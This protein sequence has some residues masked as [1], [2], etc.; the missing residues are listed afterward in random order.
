M[1]V[2]GDAAV[3]GEP[4]RVPVLARL[5]QLVPLLI[6]FVGMGISAYLSFAHS[7]EAPLVCSTGGG[8]DTVQ[9]SEYSELLGVPVALLGF[10][11]YAAI[12]ATGLVTVRGAGW[13]G[14]MAPFLVFGMALTGVLYSA[15]LTWLELY[16]IN[17]ICIWCVA[18][19]CLLTVLF[20]AATAELFVSDRLREAD[21]PP[22]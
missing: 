8:C 17:A 1:S 7:G 15:Y 3:T 12:F 9:E 22:D 5:L 4:L 11:L 20:A 16:R 13:P 14:R 2:T 6:A 18:S 10:C 19:A 21:E